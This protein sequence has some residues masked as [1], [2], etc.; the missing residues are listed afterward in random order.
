MSE[1]TL[2]DLVRN[3]TINAEIAATLWSIVAEKH[4]F[5]IVAVPRFAGKSTV[6]DAMLQ[7]VPD[8]V[9]VH[10]LSGEESEMEQLHQSADGGYLVAG[11]FSNAPAPRC[12][13]RSPIRKVFE[14]MRAGYPLST[15]LH[16]PTVEEAYAAVSQGNNLRT[17]TLPKSAT[18][19]TS[20]E[21]ATTLIR[22][23]VVLPKF[24][25]LTECWT[26]SRRVAYSIAGTPKMTLTI[27]KGIKFNTP[28]PFA[29]QDFG[30]LTAHDVAWNLNRQNAVINPSLGAAI[31]A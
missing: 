28:A 12:I 31:G 10:Q 20:S 24:T 8:D 5:M 30:E 27:R 17:K 29:G 26:A 7:F 16:A 19:S 14:T 21:W 2:V 25:K 23:G 4:S 13:W 22:S 6:G 3:G 1:T 18:W 11:E 9:P 15:A